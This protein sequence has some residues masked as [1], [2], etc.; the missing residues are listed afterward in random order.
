VY[1]RANGGYLQLTPLNV[2]ALA[3]WTMTRRSTRLG[4]AAAQGISHRLD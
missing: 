4:W 2:A 3:G 1:K